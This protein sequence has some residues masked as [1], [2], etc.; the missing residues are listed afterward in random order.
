MSHGI[1]STLGDSFVR[2]AS[3]LDPLRTMCKQI[4]S[5]LLPELL[6]HVFKIRMVEDA[7]TEFVYV[8]SFP[9]QKSWMFESGQESTVKQRYRPLLSDFER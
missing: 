4:G 7:L 1:S 2:H 5:E 9:R 6:R 8:E 3:T